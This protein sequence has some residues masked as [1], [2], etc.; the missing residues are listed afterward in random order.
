MKP[1]IISLT[2]LAGLQVISAQEKLPQEEALKYATALSADPKLLAGTPIATDVDTSKP[3]AL[4]EGEFGG[5]ILPQKNLKVEDLAPAG[6]AVVP[7]GQ[8]WLRNLTPVLD[9]SGISQDKLLLAAVTRRGE[10]ITLPKCA[11]GVRRND[12]GVLELLV[13]GK[14][15]EPLLKLPLKSIDV[16][17]ELPIDAT[18]ARTSDEGSITVKILGKYEA[19]VTVTELRL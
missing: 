3:V 17:Q 19:K 15:K 18:A 12:A 11:L 6:K 16:R 10:E 13:F 8:L 1:V 14:D 9:G 7:I 5:M 2:L 4:R